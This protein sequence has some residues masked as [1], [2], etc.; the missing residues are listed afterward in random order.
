MCG[1]WALFGVEN[2][3]F[4][5]CECSFNKIKHRGPDASRFEYD[6]GLKNAFLGFHRLDI[7]NTPFGTQPMRLYQY[8]EISLLGN[9]EIYNYQNVRRRILYFMEK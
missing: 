5:K 8:P 4:R 6:Q 3:Y 1:I 7:I 9:E 2:A